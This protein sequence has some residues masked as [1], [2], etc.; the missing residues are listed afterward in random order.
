MRGFA[1][2]LVKGLTGGFTRNIALE[3]EARGA[4]DAR[5]AALEDTIIKASVDPKKRVP[6]AL[7]NMLK[8]AQSQLEKRGPINIFGQEGPRLKLDMDKIAGLMNEVD[9]DEQKFLDYGTSKHG[10]FKIPISSEYFEQKTGAYDKA[11]IW[12]KTMDSWV[13]MNPEKVISMN[14]HLAE[15]TLFRNRYSADYINN[16]RDYKYADINNINLKNKTGVALLKDPATFKNAFGAFKNVIDDSK[17]SDNEITLQGAEDLLFGKTDKIGR[18]DKLANLNKTNSIILIDNERNA[19]VFTVKNVEN[20]KSL[21]RLAKA[22]GYNNPSL[23]VLDYRDQIQRGLKM[24]RQ[25]DLAYMDEDDMIVDY[26]DARNKYV[27]L[28]HALEVEKRG[29]GL[30]LSNMSDQEKV[31]VYDYLQ[32]AYQNNTSGMVRAFAPLMQLTDDESELFRNEAGVIA[33]TQKQKDDII[34]KYL[35]VPSINEFNDRFNAVK[36]AKRRIDR[37][38]TLEYDTQTSSGVVR[39]ISNGITKI[40]GPTGTISQIANTIFSRGDNRNKVSRESI[41][42]IL[43]KLKGEGLFENFKG[44]LLK[45]S[46]N[47]AEIESIAIILAADMARAVDPSGRL[48]NQDFEVQLRRL[49]QSGFF[50]SK[51]GDIT[52]LKTVKRDFDELFEKRK[53]IAAVL[54]DAEQDTLTPRHLQIIKANEKLNDINQEFYTIGDTP[55]VTEN[56]T[57]DMKD[58][59]GRSRMIEI[60]PGVYRDRLTKKTY[61]VQPDG[62]S[63]K[64]LTKS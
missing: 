6:L 24:G 21:Q 4:D 8:D 35:G 10:T 58:S 53:M 34:K 49:G 25:P 15:N 30:D 51:I 5:V 47:I 43:N 29:G 32:K 64:L 28:F 36:S 7:G 19:G 44:S 31:D 39:F 59:S 60:R 23:F 55:T 11:D 27:D 40:T 14:K 46:V 38:L 12:W 20:Y 45:D 37:I 61:Q 57:I 42:K 2:G 16:F 63:L 13:T 9:K 26:E 52:A 50:G 48:S 62:K 17:P 56:L 33:I 41:E 18:R 54:K 1:L 22:N 3:Q